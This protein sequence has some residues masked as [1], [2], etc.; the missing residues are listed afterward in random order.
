MSAI[1]IS[2]TVIISIVIIIRLTFLIAKV[3]SLK[4][5]RWGRQRWKFAW[6]MSFKQTKRWC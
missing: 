5:D 3:S 6:Q 2:I 4:C 1:S